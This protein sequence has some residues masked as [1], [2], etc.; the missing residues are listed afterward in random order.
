MIEKGM[1]RS[2]G[3]S[4]TELYGGRDALIALISNAVIGPSIAIPVRHWAA[5]SMMFPSVSY[6]ISVSQIKHQILTFV[7]TYGV[8]MRNRLKIF[9]AFATD[10]IAPNDSARTRRLKAGPYTNSATDLLSVKL[11]TCVSLPA[12]KVKVLRSV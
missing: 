11:A 3:G 1:Q 4:T 7:I 5:S 8:W 12:Q 2:R 10:M 9:T 6:F